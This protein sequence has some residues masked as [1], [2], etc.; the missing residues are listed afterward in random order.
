MLLEPESQNTVN[1][2]RDCWDYT[3]ILYKI[4][5]GSSP[6]RYISPAVRYVVK[7]VQPR[8]T[9]DSQ[10]CCLNLPSAK[11]TASLNPEQNGRFLSSSI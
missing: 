5:T 3:S 7:T 9:S 10:S 4:S 1:W 11:I 6:L 2:T 8:L